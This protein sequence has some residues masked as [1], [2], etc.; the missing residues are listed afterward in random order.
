MADFASSDTQTSCFQFSIHKF[1]QHVFNSKQLVIKMS[2][3][4][5]GM[6]EVFEEK[7]IFFG[8]RIRPDP[9]LKIAK[10][11]QKDES[12]MNQINTTTVFV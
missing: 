7:R 6:I 12:G 11:A 4:T 1:S 8:W 5:S 9:K 3:K 2:W 10:R